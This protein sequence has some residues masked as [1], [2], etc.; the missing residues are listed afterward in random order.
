MQNACLYTDSNYSFVLDQSYWCGWFLEQENCGK[1]ASPSKDPMLQP[2]RVS[3]RFVF[4]R[5]LTY[6]DKE[7][8]I[9]QFMF[10]RNWL[11]ELRRFRLKLASC[12]QIF[13][14]NTHP[15]LHGILAAE[16]TTPGW[17]TTEIEEVQ[18]R[19][20]R[21][22]WRD[23]CL[24]L[25]TSELVCMGFFLTAKST[26]DSWDGCERHQ[27][28]S[29]RPFYIEK[30][31]N[32]GQFGD[33]GKT[34]KQYPCRIDEQSWARAGQSKTF[35][36]KN[37]F[38]RLPKFYAIFPVTSWDVFLY[39]PQLQKSLEHCNCTKCRPCEKVLA[40]HAATPIYARPS[41][42]GRWLL[43][44]PNSPPCCPRWRRSNNRNRK[45]VV[46]CHDQLLMVFST[47]PWKHRF[48]AYV[49]LGVLWQA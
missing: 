2:P 49:D 20:R 12:L 38:E 47:G 19:Y 41:Y 45:G 8:N 3:K 25:A 11:K 9:D 31:G 16:E 14:K 5:P 10:S 30:F 24:S 6:F 28:C 26:T 34:F 40:K 13:F 35:Q 18:W 22:Q 23:L 33:Q 7:R 39:L 46:A 44:R 32:F 27:S 42:E 17:P 1:W 4:C 36:R 29:R 48:D 37:T 21:E 43:G 15:L